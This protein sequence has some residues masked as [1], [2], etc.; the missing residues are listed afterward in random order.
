MDL[1]ALPG[2]RGRLLFMVVLVGVLGGALGWVGFFHREAVMLAASP[3]IGA[4]VEATDQ[5][6]VAILYLP[7]VMK[8]PAPIYLPLIVQPP[9]PPRVYFDDFSDPT[10]G[11]YVGSA[12]RW[13]DWCGWDGKCFTG[14]EAVAHMSYLDSHYR[15]YVPLTWHGHGDVDT[16]FVWPAEYAPLPDHYYPLPETYC[17]EVRGRFATDK[18]YDPWW[19]HWGIVYGGNAARTEIFTFQVNA[20]HSV[21]APRYYNYIYPGNRQPLSGREV[22]V[23]DRIVGWSIDRG[24]DLASDKYN[25]LRVEVRGKHVY[26]YAN[27]W[28]YEVAYVPKLVRERIGLIGGSF[29]VTP[30]DIRIDYFRYQPNCEG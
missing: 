30:V 13:G 10:S 12:M 20:N 19:A 4:A 6:P 22:N 5:P 8:P 25:V 9:P 17:I 7:M 29:E 14:M 26:F 18:D 23:E 11:W 15:F 27:D 3:V 24:P 2:G 16:W 21:G 1:R 28:L